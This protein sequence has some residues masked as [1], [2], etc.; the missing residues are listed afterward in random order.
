MKH[1]PYATA[2]KDTEDMRYKA[3][4]KILWNE[5]WGVDYIKEH[6][7]VD[8]KVRRSSDDIEASQKVLSPLDPNFVDT[9]SREDRADSAEL[10]DITTTGQ[11]G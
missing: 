5:G 10:R 11:A 2:Y 4:A 8:F 9:R 1:D 6:T 3:F 7:G